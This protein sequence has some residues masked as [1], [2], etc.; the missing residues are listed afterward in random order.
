MSEQKNS[1]L[2]NEHALSHEPVPLILVSVL[3][4]VNSRRKGFNLSLTGVMLFI[5]LFI[6]TTTT[7]KTTKLY[8]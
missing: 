7:T 3:G 1:I 2:I 6:T 5:K 4:V 8:K